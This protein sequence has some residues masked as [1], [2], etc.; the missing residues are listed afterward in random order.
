MS[1]NPTVKELAQS[2]AAANE[3]TH[4]LIHAVESMQQ[5][6]SENFAQLWTTMG[7]V[8]S[9][10]SSIDDVVDALAPLRGL[11]PPSTATELDPGVADALAQI[12]D[13]LGDRRVTDFGVLNTEYDAA[14]G[15]IGAPDPCATTDDPGDQGDQ[16][17]VRGRKGS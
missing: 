5:A 14:V 11:T 15:H 9:G 16:D 12:R 8:A 13:A 10:G 3:R 17:V 6:N 7:A 4:A 2:L 1:A